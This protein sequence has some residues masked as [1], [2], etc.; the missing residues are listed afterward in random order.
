MLSILELL[1]GS[2]SLGFVI[3]S[4][5]IGLKIM[6]NYFKHKNRTFLLVGIAWIG[7][8]NPWMPDSI[9][10]L[11]YL[12]S[13]TVLNEF[14]YLLI[15]NAFIPFFLLC[16]ITAFTDLKYS[17]SQKIFL[18]ISSIAS[19][20]FEILFFSLLISDTALIGNS[21][22]P[23]QYE[24]SLFIEI[25]L[26][27]VILIVLITGV[28]FGLESMKSSERRIK[29]KGKFIIAAFILFSLGAIIDSSVPLTEI[30]VVITRIILILSSISFY[31]A[32]MFQKFIEK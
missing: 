11:M 5:I 17:S 12:T 28:L 25:Y 10:F 20:I 6:S 8:A 14:T 27:T 18:I 3:I 21:L 9:N 16:W 32:F 30:T 24:F 7:L 22:G 26:V 19:V 2:F 29:L 13:E 23:F 1:Q 4:I 15:G 31:I